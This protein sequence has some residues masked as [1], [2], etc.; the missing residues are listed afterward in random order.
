[1]RK[2]L[3]G[4]DSALQKKVLRI[5]LIP[6]FAITFVLV[7]I[8]AT[9]NSTQVHAAS[10]KASTQQTIPNSTSSGEP[11]WV[12]KAG[13]YVHVVNGIAT[14]NPAIKKVLSSR[15]VALVTQAVQKYNALPLTEKTR[16]HVPVS[17]SNHA[18][19][20]PYASCPS[21]SGAVYGPYYYWWGEAVTLNHCL[22]QLL[23][24][25]V[26]VDGS[27]ALAAGAFCAVASAGACVLFDAIAG[28]Y[29][30]GTVTALNSA[31]AQCDNRGANL[32]ITFGVPVPWV[33]SVC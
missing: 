21:N 7:S 11:T 23:W 30:A 27:T 3:R 1:M 18:T 26:Y 22:I 9:G 17:V 20:I 33:N 12:V 15:D 14:I 24:I 16:A 5:T 29:I 31:D 32:N 25:A 28:A 13:S 2:T 19:V 4:R 6:L 10:I 8:F